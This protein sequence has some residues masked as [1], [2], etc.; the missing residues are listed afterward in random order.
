MKRANG[1]LPLPAAWLAVVA[2]SVA[3]FSGSALAQK[4]EG[5]EVKVKVETV[6]AKGEGQTIDP[7]LEPMARAFKLGQLPYTSF[8]RL[9]STNIQ[10]RKGEP[11]LIQLPNKRTATMTLKELK[12]GTA[13]LGMKVADLTEAEVTLGKE[14]SVYQIGGAHQ[15]G[16]IVLVLSPA[17]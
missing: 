6:L 10:I 14:G 16:M 12:E 9:D 3:F 2:L 1:V 5:P 13:K 17:K 11:A 7:G 15:G 4:S 8:K